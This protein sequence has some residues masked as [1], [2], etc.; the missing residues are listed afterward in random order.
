MKSYR[1]GSAI[2]YFLVAAGFI[3]LLLA[4][5]YPHYDPDS[6]GWFL[7]TSIG[8]RILG[9]K[10]T[11]IPLEKVV[12]GVTESSVKSPLDLECSTNSDCKTYFAVNQCQG[13][14]GNLSERN[15][16]AITQL[17]NQR[18]CDPS[19]WSRPNLDCKCISG[20]CLSLE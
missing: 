5:P 7:G 19:Q 16:S 4:I 9:N 18:V 17:N 2:F 13:Y 1:G 3:V 14:C 8:G 20:R 11:G 15:N 10:S 6:G 12:V